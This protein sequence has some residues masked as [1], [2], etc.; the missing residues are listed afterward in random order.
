[1][2]SRL[3]Y[4]VGCALGGTA[5]YGLIT[6]TRKSDEYYNVYCYKPP[7]FRQRLIDAY[8]KDGFQGLKNKTLTVSDLSNIIGKI[9]PQDVEFVSI[10]GQYYQK[11]QLKDD[12]IISISKHGEFY[13]H[14]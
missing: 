6:Q 10:M 3:F 7:F 14:E 11:N 2:N 1:M 4:G 8:R 5:I 13:I 9:D 12:D